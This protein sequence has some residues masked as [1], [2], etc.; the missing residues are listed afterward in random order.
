DTIRRSRPTFVTEIMPYGLIEQ[1]ANLEQLLNFLIPFGY[2]LYDERTEAP[3]P[4]EAAAL[5]RMIGEGGSRN[6]IAR[7]GGRGI[8][9]IA[10]EVALYCARF[11]MNNSVSLPR[12]YPQSQD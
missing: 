4:S 9:S 11:R 10:K 1:G 5:E 3:L 2:R 7:A 8:F 12:Q 6:V